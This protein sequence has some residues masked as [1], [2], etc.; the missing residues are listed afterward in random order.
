[1]NRVYT[2]D[3]YTS[4]CTCETTTGVWSSF[5]L[6]TLP[7]IVA[8]PSVTLGNVHLTVDP[9]PVGSTH[10][11][12]AARCVNTHSLV[13]TRRACNALVYIAVTERAQPARGT[14]TGEAYN[15]SVHG[16]SLVKSHIVWHSVTGDFHFT[17]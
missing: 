5:G 7:S 6:H 15:R 9:C 1:M 12:I 4:G 17:R 16:H 2:C 11:H 14:H 10:T 13:N 8:R 3:M